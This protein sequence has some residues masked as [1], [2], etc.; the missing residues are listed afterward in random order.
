MIYLY[1]VPY[2][3]KDETVSQMWI[4]TDRQGQTKTGI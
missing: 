4:L 3:P 1:L 2:A